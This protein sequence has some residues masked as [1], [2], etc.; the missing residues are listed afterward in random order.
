MLEQKSPPSLRP[1]FGEVEPKDDV[2]GEEDVVINMAIQEEPTITAVRAVFYRMGLSDRDIVA[3]LC[4]GHVY[5]RCH[6]ELSGYAGPWVEEMTKFSNE[7]GKP[8]LDHRLAP[9]S[10]PPPF[11]YSFTKRPICWRMNGLR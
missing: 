11:Y 7:Y 5:G 10:P 9:A 2:A 3:L 6:P 1:I 4:G 8:T